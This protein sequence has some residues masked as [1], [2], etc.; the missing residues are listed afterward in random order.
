M[1]R[2]GFCN[3]NTTPTQVWGLECGPQPQFCPL[4]KLR[5]GKCLARIDLVQR[6][7]IARVRLVFEL[8]FVAEDLGSRRVVV[9]RTP[10]GPASPEEVVLLR[11]VTYLPRAHGGTSFFVGCHVQAPTLTLASLCVNIEIV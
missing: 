1:V 2:V 5:M 3:K 11:Y 6:T 9:V 8:L 4:A 7:R 10:L